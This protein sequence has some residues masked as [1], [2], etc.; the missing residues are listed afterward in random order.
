MRYVDKV[1]ENKLL[2][3]VVAIYLVLFIIMP[4]KAMMSVQN[5]MYYV[6]EMLIIMPVIFLLTAIIEAW[7][8]REMIMNG[9]GEKSGFK[10]NIY[11]FLLGSFSAGPI[12]AAFPISKML[13]KKGA[14]ITNIVIILS[15]WAVIKIPMLANE[16]KFL[17]VKFMGIRWILTVIAILCMGYIVSLLVNKNTI[18][19]IVENKKLRENPIEINDKYCVGCG[20][21]VRLAPDH[22]IMES[23]IARWTQVPIGGKEIQLKTV[24]EK[25]PAK[26]ISISSRN[27]A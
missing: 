8:P 10:G 1:K 17:G 9:F 22:F 24:A 11:S 3:V 15:S 16:A 2:A 25:C 7:V 18:P 23:N 5:S 13:L 21:C 14:S 20:L 12:Y 27:T 26:V 19:D 4:D 6:K